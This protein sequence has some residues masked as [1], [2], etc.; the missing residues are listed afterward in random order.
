[1]SQHVDAVDVFFIV[2][3]GLLIAMG[4]VAVIFGGMPQ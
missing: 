3:M 2:V 4:I 1:M